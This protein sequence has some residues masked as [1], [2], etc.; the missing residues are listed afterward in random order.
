MLVSA[1]FV[2]LAYACFRG[3]TR[4]FGVV[5][6]VLAIGFLQDPV[7]KV[8]AGEPV[9]MTIM[10]GLV[11]ASMALRLV[12]INPRAIAEPFAR[13]TDDVAPSV[14]IFLLVIGLQGVHSLVRYGSPVLT[15]LGAIFYV[16]PL[17]AIVVAYA[18]FHRFELVRNFMF[19]FCV[20]AVAVSLSVVYSYSGGE[21]QLLGEVGSG[22]VIYDQ[23]TILKAYS[24]LMRSSEI[25]SW[26]M[27][28]CVCFLIVLVVDRGNMPIFLIATLSIVLLIG[29]IILTGRRKM[30]IQI[31]I[32]ASMYFPLL[33]YYQQRLSNRFIG[34]VLLGSVVLSILYIL[35]LPSFQGTD[36]DLY[37]ARGVSVFED[38]GERFSTLGLGTI[39]WA[40][41]EHG[42][43]GGGLGVASQGA[44]HFVSGNT[45][46]AGEGGIGKLVSE[47]GLLSLFVVA[48]LGISFARYLHKCLNLVSVS[49]PEKLPFVVGILV[50]LLANVPTFAIASQV[51][52]DVFVLI[53][54]GFLA[55]ALFALPRQVVSHLEANKTIL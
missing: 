33:R 19:A 35:V 38:A 14:T 4:D 15:G 12:L 2:L 26:H 8:L 3:L 11:V 24:G 23:G 31:V 51:Y 42:F 1:F 34:L 29:A 16:A 10:V 43:F 6:F 40:F 30:I 28:V 20:L 32:F 25:A 54:L 53:I 5:T 13:W 41:R 21:S 55:G 52:G 17:V 7:R 22:L 49:I 18:H 27:G 50:F 46:G 44:Q 37:L 39:S 48:W 45:G 47:L 36:Y 9:I